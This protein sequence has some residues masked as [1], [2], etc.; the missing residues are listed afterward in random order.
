MTALPSQ[1]PLSLDKITPLLLVAVGALVYANA[2][3]VPFLYDDFGAIVD[4]ADIRQLWPPRWALP[5]ESPQAPT[6]SRP[7]VSFTLALNYAIG[8]LEPA[9]YRILNIAVHILC[10]LVLFGVARR[11]LRMPRLVEHCGS[12]AGSLVLAA[13]LLWL[14]HPLG[15]QCVDYAIQRSESLMA[16]FYLLTLYCAVRRG[17]SGSGIWAAA[18]VLACA[19]GMASKEAMVTA[20]LLVLLHDRTFLSGSF[21][22]A[23]RQHRNLYIGLGS[24]WGL[25]GLLLSTAPHGRSIGFTTEVTAWG[26]ALNQTRVVLGYLRKAFWPQNLTVDYGYPQPLSLAD[27][28]PETALLLSLLALAA[29]AVRRWPAAGFW[30]VWFFLILAPTSSLVPIVN[31]VGA[32]RRA[33]LPLA[34]LAVL[35]VL[36][37]HGFLRSR[38]WPAWVG[39]A[40]LLLVTATFGYLTVRQNVLYADPLALWREAADAVPDNPRAHTYLGLASKQRGQVEEAIRRYQRALQIDPTYAEAHGNLGIVLAEA[41]QTEAAIDHFRQALEAHPEHAEFHNNLGNALLSSGQIDR[42]MDHFERALEMRP[43]YADA[44]GNLG[45]ALAMQGRTQEAIAQFENALR[46]DPGYARGHYNLGITYMNLGQMDRAVARLRRA[47]EI[48]PRFAAARQALEGVLRT[49]ED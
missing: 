44:R 13:A 22:T 3:S 20:P 49:Q 40:V 19:A 25:L 38:R 7:V 45:I 12:S 11:T 27:V 9:G 31:E 48:D 5:T 14:V 23:L 4:N 43:H 41:G 6:N 17:E 42:A 16:L 33:Y 28:L 8:G 39:P 34:G 47:L 30:G 32:E 35:A 24:T 26:Y 1:S 15:A 37:A 18:A 36:A 29:V 21:G 46:T 10:S 2:L